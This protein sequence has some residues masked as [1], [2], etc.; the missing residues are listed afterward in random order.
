MLLSNARRHV[1]GDYIIIQS[2][3]AYLNLN[4]RAHLWTSRGSSSTRVSSA[5]EV[6]DDRRR[7]YFYYY[8]PVL[9]YA[10]W[11]HSTQRWYNNELV[12]L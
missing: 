5:F 4:E 6:S 12:G 1:S 7:R 2:S 3:V 8:Y 9:L 11:T 10:E